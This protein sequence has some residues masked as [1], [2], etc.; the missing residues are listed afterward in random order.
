[1]FKGLNG[2]LSE[3]KDFRRR[4]ENFQHELLDILMLSICA[5]FSGAE[6]FV[7]IELYGKQKKSFLEGFIPLEKGIPSHDTIRR[8]FLHLDPEVFNAKFMAWVQEC[9]KK[10]N[11][12]YR[13][14]SIDGKTLRGSKSGIHLVSAVASELGISLGQV[15]TDEKSNEI[16]AIPELLDLLL[17]KGCIVSIDALGCQ[18]DI[19]KKIVDAEADY[20][21][22]LKG[23]Q[24][25]LRKEVEEQF[26]H[27]YRDEPHR[28]SLWTASH[29]G[30]VNYQVAVCN[31][32][33]LIGEADKWKGLAS[34]IRVETSTEKGRETRYYI[35]SIKNLSQKQ[36]MGLAQNHWSIENRLHWQLDVTMREDEKRHRTKFAPENLSLLRKLFLNMAYARNEKI[37]KKKLLKKMAWDDDFAR[38]IFDDLFQNI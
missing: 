1:M 5:V 9:L 32:I 38:T 3:I 29:N 35:S 20:F 18:R 36:A 12:E 28:E 22:A 27:T 11:L 2:H 8:V 25:C 15:K 16:T 19:A 10:L 30:V 14:I 26:S 37:S 33:D 31:R 24:P 13:H 34:L 7:E 6:D 21:L 23:N 17:L 4:N